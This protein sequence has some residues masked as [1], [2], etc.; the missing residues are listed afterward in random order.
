MLKLAS[1]VCS[2]AIPDE[3]SS[4]S[5]FWIMSHHY[6]YP[7]LLCYEY[8]LCGGFSFCSIISKIIFLTPMKHT[9]CPIFCLIVL[10]LLQFSEE[11]YSLIAVLLYAN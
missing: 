5:Y 3:H 9:P 6:T 2:D 8:L 1:N 7:L 4:A 10:L 11:L